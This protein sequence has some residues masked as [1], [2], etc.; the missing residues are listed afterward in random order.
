MVLIGA[1]S[2]FAMT[3]RTTVI[4]GSAASQE[5]GAASGI[6]TASGKLGSALGTALMTTYFISL[7][8]TEYVSQMKGTGLSLA[9]LSEVTAEWKRVAEHIAGPELN[10]ISP[11][12]LQQIQS[13][14]IKAYSS[15]L[16]H[17]EFVAF[18]LLSFSAFGI[19]FTMKSQKT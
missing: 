11:S 12:L 1:G 2:A 4:L 8:K 14:Y 17:S 5:A 6:N 7:A 13:R 18:L 10:R 16:A 9:K 19:L 3:L 15:A